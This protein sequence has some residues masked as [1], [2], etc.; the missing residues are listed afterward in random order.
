MHHGPEFAVVFISI[1][2]LLI[3]AVMRI[4]SSKT[5]FPY[6]IG[7]MVVGIVV[8][9]LFGDSGVV[10]GHEHE[11]GLAS[12]LMLGAAID[13][14]LIIFVFLPA[15]VFESAYAID[16]SEFR[17][18]LGAIVVFAVPAL[19]LSTL[20]VAGVM[21]S[22]TS[23][24]WAWSWPAAVVCGALISATDPVAVVAI[25]RELGVSKR[26]GTLIEGE[27]LLNDGTAIVVFTLLMAL[28]SGEVSEFSISHALFEFIKV[29]SG[30]IAVGAVLAFVFSKW[31][32]KLFN[33]PMAEISITLI[34]AYSAMIIA[35]GLLHVSGVMAVVVAGLWMSGQGK[36]KI[37]P[38]VQHFL[39]R[40]W[41]MLG[42]IANTLI[43]FLVGLVIAVQAAHAAPMD[44]VM[45]GVTY[46]GAM[47]VRAVLPYGFQPI[48]NRVSEGV[49]SGDS[50]VITWGGLRGAVSLALALIVAQNE[51]IDPELRRQILLVT[52]GV[53]MLTIL[54]NG[55]TIGRL[56]SKLGYDEPPMG[57]RLRL[58]AARSRALAGVRHEVEEVSRDLR[59][60]SWGEVFGR[61]D[62]RQNALNS[63]LN[64]AKQALEKAPEA[65]RVAAYWSRALDV[66]RQAYWSAYDHGTL[67]AGA[68]KRL[69]REIERQADNFARGH[70]DAPPSR[71]PENISVGLFGGLFGGTGDAFEQSALTYDLSRAEAQ[72]ADQVLHALDAMTDVPEEILAPI[73]ETYLGYRRAGKERIEDM[74]VNLPEMASAIEERLARRIELNFEREQ[75]ESLGHH[76]AIDHD[77]MEEQLRD[78]DV[79]MHQLAQL[80]TSVPIPETA[81]LVAT[82]PMFASL[83]AGARELL[84][85]ITEEMVLRPGDYLF[86][87]DDPGSSLFVIARGAVNV[88]LGKGEM[89]VDTLGG[90]DI[91]GEISLLTGAPRTASVRAATSVTLG[92][93]ER[94]SFSALLAK[95]EHFEGEVWMAFA[96]RSFDNYLR[97]AGRFGHLSG[98]QRSQWVD[99]GTMNCLEAGELTGPESSRYVLG[100]TGEMVVD[101]VVHGAVALAEL[102]SDRRISCTGEGRAVFL[103]EPP[104]RSDSP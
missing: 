35:E 1:V 59:T 27:S 75:Y 78:V 69:S 63:E 90:G 52:A 42:Y 18:S 7:M 57:E 50:A 26:L 46:V 94:E 30:G 55:S 101:G 56:L 73:K 32:G 81:V 96:R 95:S 15:L 9:M 2:A 49:S 62:E 29:V 89:V 99:S 84:A 38:E 98:A 21:V 11:G 68:V 3:G 92:K 25:L 74:R 67:A 53:V 83:D 91:I 60:V 34:L 66:E 104:E 61:L 48:A 14:H 16:V 28:L 33:D 36:T 97:R 87:Q 10:H 4:V 86:H 65:T 45:I 5:G 47:L 44:F 93:I 40:F 71:L 51:N 41:E 39:H 77:T 70:L 20:M 76:G 19:V 12:V 43:F 82:T 23:S 100:V 6:T 8:G 64:E 22:V 31:I 13:P 103:G 85:D 54:V 58:L 72:A 24:S 102:G 80:T 88:L 17:K 37:S 79:Q